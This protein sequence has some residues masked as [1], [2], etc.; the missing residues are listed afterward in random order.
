MRFRRLRSGEGVEELLEMKHSMLHGGQW[1][2][3]GGEGG[4]G[5]VGYYYY[6]IR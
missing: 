5:R 1:T 6:C 3:V 2:W 4:W